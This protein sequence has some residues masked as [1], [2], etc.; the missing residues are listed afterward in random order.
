MKRYLLLKKL[1]KD[2]FP[3]SARRSLLRK[4]YDELCSDPYRLLINSAKDISTQKS[5]SHDSGITLSGTLY[6][7]YL[8]ALV[9]GTITAFTLLNYNGQEPVNAI[10]FIFVSMILPVAGTIF[11]LSILTISILGKA[12]RHLPFPLSIPEKILSSHLRYAHEMDKTLMASFSMLQFQILS[13]LFYTGVAIGLIA[14]IS[15]ED[16]AFVWSTTLHI[17]SGTLHSILEN[18]SIFWRDIFPSA[19]P[20]EEL[21]SKSRFYRLGGVENEIVANR[22]ILGEWWRF[23]FAGTL[24]YGVVLRLVTL[25]LF[26]AY[27]RS[28]EKKSILQMHEAVE[29]VESICR[30]RVESSSKSPEEPLIYERS[31]EAGG[32]LLHRYDIAFGW[33]MDADTVRS[34]LSSSGTETSQ[35]AESGFGRDGSD[36]IEK[37]RP[38]ALEGASIVVVVKSWE[39]PIM[40]F[41]DFIEELKEMNPVRIDILPAGFA[42]ESYIADEKDLNIWR[43]KTA[44][45]GVGKCTVVS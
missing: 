10:Y 20:S 7:L 37:I 34:V 22:E 44:Y 41:F 32:R 4:K 24:F 6:T 15:V 16:I 39:P 2:D 9:L 31:P 14:D 18:L 40:D 42:D 26:V 5:V 27:E 25:P 21:I 11:S 17:E 28:V 13:I 8:F 23:L 30:P 33:Y 29:L 43:D 1:L 38:R 3:D 35:I 36:D 45:L 12:A 19:V